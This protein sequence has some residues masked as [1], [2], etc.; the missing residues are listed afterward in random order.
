[1]PHVAGKKNIETLKTHLS[2][3]P[4]ATKNVNT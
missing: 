3:D 1:M 2:R 4:A